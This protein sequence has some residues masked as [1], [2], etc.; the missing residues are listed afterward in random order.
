MLVQGSRLRLYATRVD[1]G[2]GRR[3]RTE[4]FIECDA[5]LL[6]DRNLA[7]LWLFCSAEAL[8]PNGSLEE[9]LGT[10]KRFAGGLADVLRKRIYESVVPKLARSVA[11]ARGISEPGPADLER[12]LSNVAH[13]LVSTAL[14]CVCGRP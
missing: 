7:Y 2:I 5:A 12:D 13:H 10:S 11:A 1:I 3:G 4:T 14:R 6:S 9:V 8:E